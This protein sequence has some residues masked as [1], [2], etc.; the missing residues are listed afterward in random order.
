MKIM[1]QDRDAVIDVTNAD[2]FTSDDGVWEY[3]VSVKGSKKYSLGAYMEPGRAAKELDKIF[4]YIR[5]KKDT[6]IMSRE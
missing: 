4:Q 6:Y 3:V 2:I 5:T 1:V